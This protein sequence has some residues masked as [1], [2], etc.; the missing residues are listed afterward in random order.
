MKKNHGI[1]CSCNECQKIRNF[2]KKKEKKGEIY[3]SGLEE[4][5]KKIRR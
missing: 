5:K 2:L 4:D 3:I 1:D